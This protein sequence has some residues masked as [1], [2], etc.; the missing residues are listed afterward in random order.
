ML[1]ISGAVDWI[2]LSIKKEEEEEEEEEGEEEKNYAK[3]FHNILYLYRFWTRR[4]AHMRSDIPIY[5][6]EFTVPPG[7]IHALVPSNSSLVKPSQYLD[8]SDLSTSP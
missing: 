8:N 6:R 5:T 1:Y 3:F 2:Y 4:H 7:A